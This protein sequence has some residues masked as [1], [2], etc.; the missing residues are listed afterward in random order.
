MS[1]SIIV[2]QHKYEM[3]S[4][5]RFNLIV[6]ISLVSVLYAFQPPNILNA[7]MCQGKES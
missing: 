4:L 6:Q 7:R 1:S 5:Q 3:K 2:E